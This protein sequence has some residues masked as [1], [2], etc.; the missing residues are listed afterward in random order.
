[1]L[2]RTRKYNFIR[3]EACNYKI[4]GPEKRQNQEDTIYWFRRKINIRQHF[5]VTF[6]ENRGKQKNY[7]DC[8]RHWKR[9]SCLGWRFR[10]CLEL[11]QTRRKHFGSMELKLDTIIAGVTSVVRWPWGRERSTSSSSSST[12]QHMTPHTIGNTRQHT[13]STSLS[14]IMTSL[15]QLSSSWLTFLFFL[16]PTLFNLAGKLTFLTFCTF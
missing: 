1:M 15:T 2:E 10:F 5:L 9:T 7:S 4:E 13:T 14:F 12:V 8:G 3:L 16:V 11:C 6:L